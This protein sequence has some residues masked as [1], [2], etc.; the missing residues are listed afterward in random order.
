MVPLQSTK[1]VFAQLYDRYGRSPGDLL[2]V[3]GK[4]SRFGFDLSVLQST[5][6][7]ASEMQ[8]SKH[9]DHQDRAESEVERVELD[10][11]GHSN[12][13]ELGLNVFMWCWSREIRRWVSD[14]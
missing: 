10:L 8:L 5:T 12:G 7:S 3:A 4:S 6:F 14:R 9:E 13:L 1:L 11:D 2:I